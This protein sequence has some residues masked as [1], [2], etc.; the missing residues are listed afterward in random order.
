[1]ESELGIICQHV[2]A[3]IFLSSTLSI[4][5]S[6]SSF[7]CYFLLP[8]G[9]KILSRSALLFDVVIE[10]DLMNFRKMFHSLFL[11]NFHGLI[12]KISIGN[13]RRWK[14]ITLF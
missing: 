1:M 14:S 11:G 8:R 10:S 6:A 9:A 5:F 13:F 12:V 4:T 2:D 3:V 7:Y